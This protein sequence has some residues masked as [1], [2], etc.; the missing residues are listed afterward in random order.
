MVCREEVGD[1][2][3][4]ANFFG[5]FL[6]QKGSDGL[7]DDGYGQVGVLEDLINGKR[8]CHWSYSG[9]KLTFFTAFSQKRDAEIWQLTKRTQRM[10]VPFRFVPIR[11]TKLV[12]LVMF[13]RAR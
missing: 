9:R 10:L 8:P 13:V 5:H 6:F 11:S 12:G 7:G 1:W 3:P 2:L 4:D